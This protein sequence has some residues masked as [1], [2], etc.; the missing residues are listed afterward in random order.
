MLVMAEINQDSEESGEDLGFLAL[1]EAA[2]VVGYKGTEMLRLA[3]KRGE[4]PAYRL[5][6]L[7]VVVRK[8]DLVKWILSKPIKPG[9][10]E[11]KAEKPDFLVAAE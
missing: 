9:K 8:E 11:K 6:R 3:I 5:A 4:L 10:A 1:P 2:K 7:K